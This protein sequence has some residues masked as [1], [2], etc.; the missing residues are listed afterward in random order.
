MVFVSGE[1]AESKEQGTAET[2]SETKWCSKVFIDGNPYFVGGSTFM[3]FGIT[4][5]TLF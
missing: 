5:L 4:N 1:G 3:A 2:E